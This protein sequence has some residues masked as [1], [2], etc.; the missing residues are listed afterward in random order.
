MIHVPKVLMERVGSWVP[1]IFHG[2]GRTILFSRHTL[3]HVGMLLA[4][5][6]L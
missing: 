5:L 4:E 3:F 2:F 6:C 1:F